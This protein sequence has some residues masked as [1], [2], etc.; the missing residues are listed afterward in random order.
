M[1]VV[2]ISRQHGCLGDKIAEGVAAE[3]GLRLVDHE[4]IEAVASRLG[5]PETAVTARDDR[6]G[7]LVRDLVRTMQRLYPATVVP[8]P[9]TEPDLDDAA[10][11][12]VIQ[13]TIREVARSG[14]GVIL[15]RAA[16]FILR[17]DPNVLDILL[18]APLAVRLERVMERENVNRQTA[19]RR[20]REVDASRARYTR[21][22][23]GADWLGPDAY[24]L[25]L[26]TAYFAIPQA[27]SLVCAT[28][29][30]RESQG[31]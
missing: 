28:L 27:V 2:T 20:I 17:D 24:D 13:Q 7:N 11:L 4:I 26:N 8:R 22:F 31:S 19:L 3:L 21:H 9:S 10:Y 15:G 25:V 30:S 5:V 1:P 18:V 12:S 23:Y 6:E 29:S 16:A 14:N